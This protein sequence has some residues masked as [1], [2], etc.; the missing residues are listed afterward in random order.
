MRSAATR[1]S[2]AD[3]TTLVAIVRRSWSGIRAWRWKPESTS[4]SIM[5]R[6]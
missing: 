4:R 5:Y 1:S 3:L 6:R 2:G